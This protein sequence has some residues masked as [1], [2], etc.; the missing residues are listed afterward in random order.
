MF[1]VVPAQDIK[2]GWFSSAQE[3][4]LTLRGVELGGGGVYPLVGSRGAAA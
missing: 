1:T 3:Q 4:A 2:T